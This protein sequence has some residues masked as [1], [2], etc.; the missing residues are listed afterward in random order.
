MQILD[1]EPMYGSVILNS[2][3]YYSQYMEILTSP[4]L[5]VSMADSNEIIWQVLNCFKHINESDI[6]NELRKLPDFDHLVAKEILNDSEKEKK[7]KDTIVEFGL[8][9][10]NEVKTLGL[11]KY[12][13][14]DSYELPYYLHQITNGRIIL[15]YLRT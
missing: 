4:D 7:F 10:F 1:E 5:S 12:N 15:K 8:R 11:I 3:W 6:E 2:N 14:N 13:L 9:L